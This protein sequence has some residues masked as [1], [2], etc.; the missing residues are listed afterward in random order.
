MYDLPTLN[1]QFPQDAN[2][3]QGRGRGNYRDMARQRALTS[4][5]SGGA[6]PPIPSGANQ[7]GAPGAIAPE[8][9]DKQPASY[10][11]GEGSPKPLDQ[12]VAGAMQQ[13]RDQNSMIG[14]TQD[15]PQQAALGAAIGG[16]AKN[17]AQEAPPKFWAGPMDWARTKIAAQKAAEKPGIDAFGGTLQRA[18]D[19]AVAGK[20]VA[21]GAPLGTIDGPLP[22]LGL[23]EALPGAPGIAGP[24]T[25]PVL[26][27][28]GAPVPG[29][30]PKSS[31]QASW[32]TKG[33][34]TPNYT[35]TRTGLPPLPGFDAGKWNDPNAQQPKYVIGGILQEAAGGD[36]LLQTP[37]ERERAVK[38]IQAAY[39]GTFDGKDKIAIPGIGT[40]DIFGG[41][42]NGLYQGTYQVVEGTG[43]APDGSPLPP[44]GAPDGAPGSPL[45]GFVSN[46]RY[47]S[48]N[49]QTGGDALQVIYDLLGPLMGD[50]T[51]QNALQNV[52]KGGL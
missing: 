28:S 1:N 20:Q 15:A 40:I 25:D 22:E 31:P 33:Y 34:A 43:L 4:A 42:G 9:P 13:A 2:P 27:P 10:T 44:E 7:G 21:E 49:T 5:V 24:A 23:P 12:A 37:E 6:Q 41:A 32:N 50:L 8:P 48:N 46:N 14:G 35:V 16:A 18:L 45:D 17:A 3:F 29:T 30:D 36:G 19:Q 26:D 47:R 38:N 11:G 39:G 52:L 51:K